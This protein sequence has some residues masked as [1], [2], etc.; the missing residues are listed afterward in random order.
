MGGEVGPGLTTA[1]KAEQKKAAIT[2]SLFIPETGLR[3]DSQSSSEFDEAAL[4]LVLSVK[5]NLFL[6]RFALDRALR[7]VF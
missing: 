4:A 1:Y 7:L 6:F 5:R 3:F 2:G